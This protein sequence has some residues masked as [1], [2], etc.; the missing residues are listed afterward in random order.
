MQNKTEHVGNDKGHVIV[1]ILL[2]NLAVAEPFPL[3]SCF[4]GL[5][6]IL[7]KR[8][9]VFCP[10]CMDHSNQKLQGQM[11]TSFFTSRLDTKWKWNLG[12]NTQQRYELN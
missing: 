8:T 2:L 9:D 1:I 6:W 7:M 10:F 12:G 3:G 5:D 11:A 4:F